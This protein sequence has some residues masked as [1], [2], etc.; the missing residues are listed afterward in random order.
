MRP[1]LVLLAVCV[2]LAGASCASD[3]PADE[4]AVNC[5][6]ANGP[7]WESECRAA[8]D[9]IVKQYAGERRRQ[10]IAE[11][12]YYSRWEVCF[13]AYGM[14]D[15]EDE[16]RKFYECEEKPGVYVPDQ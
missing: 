16:F 7:A 14:S 2:V 15:D 4:I 8:A 1:L 13:W 6:D 9:N 12:I 10:Q 3:S 11:T 5:V